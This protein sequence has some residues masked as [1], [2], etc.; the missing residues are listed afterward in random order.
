M[1]TRLALALSLAAG[2]FVV[3]AAPAA[4][5]D[6][7]GTKRRPNV[8]FIA[9]DDLRPNLGC[10]GDRIA[11][12]PHIDSLAAR[13]I[14]F[15]RAYCQQAV[16]NPSRASVMNG[17]RPDTLKVWNLRT[18][19]RKTLPDVVTLPQH[20]KQQGYHT[21]SIGKVYHG[22]P[23]MQDRP[24]WSVASTMSSVPKSMDYLLQH[25]RAKSLQ[26]KMAATED[27]D[28]ADD[29]YPGGQVADLAI[30]ALREL[31]DKPFFLAVGFRKPHLPFSS[32][33]KYWDIYDR[34]KIP[35]PVDRQ[36][37][38][39][40]PSIALHDGRELRGYKD[41]PNSGTLSDE[42]VR[43][44]RHGYYACISYTDAQVG[45]LV[46]ELDRLKLTDNTIG[47][48]WSDHGFHLGEHGL[49][50]KTS[51][52]ELDARVP[53]ILA[54]PGKTNRGSKTDALVELVDIYPSLVELCGLPKPPDGLE[55]TSMVPLIDKP[56]RPW[57]AA[58]FTLFPRPSYYKQ[59]PVAM[60]YSIRTDQY[61][62]TEWI[63]W[64]TRK[65]IAR[66]LYDH[67]ADRMETVNLASHP[68]SAKTVSQL[69]ETLRAGWKSVRP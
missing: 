68:E 26:L 65:V 61:R 9:I 34:N 19:F 38:R 2:W 51:N 46:R 33:R 14:V 30:S 64:E 55:G 15:N 12:T 3:T 10:Y 7:V 17:R 66:E 11:K 50:C 1:T 36:P 43:Q 69:Q 21:R 13:G 39:D 56:N 28:V 67:D 35:M 4:R 53:L 54:V 22:K 29:A 37:P 23:A 31:K 20:F 8:L 24:S 60:G 45:K 44:L 52:F 27:A 16:C 25:N 6:K 49:W 59:Q 47:V 58:A 48:F 32:P 40:A 5:A 63:D 42:K 62:F 18:H 57:K 41:I